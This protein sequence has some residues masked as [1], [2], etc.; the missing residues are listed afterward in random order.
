MRERE[1]RLEQAAQLADIP[2]ERSSADAEL[3][4][5]LERHLEEGFDDAQPEMELISAERSLRMMRAFKEATGLLTPRGSRSDTLQNSDT[6]FQN[7]VGQGKPR[8]VL[9]T[10]APRGRE[11][12]NQASRF[13]FFPTALSRATMNLTTCLLSLV[14]GLSPGAS[15]L[16][17]EWTAAGSVTDAQGN[18]LVG[19]T[20]AAFDPVSLEMLSDV[21]VGADGSYQIGGS[22]KRFT[23]SPGRLRAVTSPPSG[24]STRT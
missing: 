10:R 6:P 12:T 8:P 18:A 15:T 2:D 9:T 19:A 1:E 24:S 5:E 4:E 17:T 23:S 20:V 21:P 16:P 13:D 22:R 14:A 3:I 11:S 7:T